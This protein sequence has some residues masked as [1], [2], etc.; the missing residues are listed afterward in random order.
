[1]K[2][3]QHIVSFKRYIDKDEVS[4]NDYFNKNIIC[5]K[6]KITV[7]IRKKDQ[8]QTKLLTMT[9]VLYHTRLAAFA[10]NV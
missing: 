2:K 8:C 9:P 1:M 10:S 3:K 4:F 7:L 6:K 5:L